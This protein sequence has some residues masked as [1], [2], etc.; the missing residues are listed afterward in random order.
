MNDKFLNYGLWGTHLGPVELMNAD[1]PG[2]LGRYWA[3]FQVRILMPLMAF[4]R[5]SI[6]IIFHDCEARDVADGL[7]RSRDM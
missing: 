3:W 7:R 1:P 5:G 6:A 4:N 2:S